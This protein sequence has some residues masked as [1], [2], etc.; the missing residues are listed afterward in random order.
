MK[1]WIVRV[2]RAAYVMAETEADAVRQ[3]GDI[4]RWEDEA[5]VTAEPLESGNPLG[6][7]ARSLVYHSGRDDFTLESARRLCSPP[8]DAFKRGTPQGVTSRETEG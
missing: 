2:E 8:N 1:L 4:E 3:Q 5:T 7:D 6:W